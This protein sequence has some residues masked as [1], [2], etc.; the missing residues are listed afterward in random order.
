MY[1][2]GLYILNP[3]WTLKP[4]LEETLPFLAGVLGK[5]EDRGWEI[6]GTGEQ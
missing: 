4:A 5:S 3:P 1:G 2:S 6:M